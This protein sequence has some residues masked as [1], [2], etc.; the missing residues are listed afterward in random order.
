MLLYA[1]M[2]SMTFILSESKINGCSVDDILSIQNLVNEVSDLQ[3]LY[4][5]G[6]IPSQEYVDFF[7]NKLVWSFYVIF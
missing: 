6:K 2:M 1:V 5:I 7:N 3:S 4:Q